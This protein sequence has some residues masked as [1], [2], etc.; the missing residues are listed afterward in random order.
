MV[1]A[2]LTVRVPELRAAG[3][4]QGMAVVLWGFL[5]LH[6]AGSRVP[7]GSG[8]ALATLLFSRGRFAQRL[9]PMYALG[10]DGLGCLLPEIPAL[11][12]ESAAP[13]PP[14]VGEELGRQ[15]S[16]PVLGVC[17]GKW[18]RGG[19][20]VLMHSCLGNEAV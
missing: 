5:F 6:T 1:S 20:A 9:L 4:R 7:L 10:S 15:L 14:V 11:S 17:F 3:L 19:L 13:V 18:L 12:T 2:V 16:C 8:C